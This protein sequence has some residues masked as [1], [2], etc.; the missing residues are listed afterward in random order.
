MDRY[1]PERPLARFFLWNDMHIRARE[2]EHA[3]G[4]YRGSN[5]RAAWAV[6]CAL[7]QHGFAPPD[8][9]VLAGDI[10]NGEEAHIQGEYQAVRE[11]VLD[12]LPMPVLPC[13]GNHETR[14]G[15]DDPRLQGAYE[16]TFGAGWF[17]Y[18]FTLAGFGFIVVDTG[19]AHHIRDER[20][21][22]RN[23]FVGRALERLR[24]MPVFVVTHVP[25]IAMREQ[26]PLMASF[27]F[28]TWRVLDPGLREMVEAHREQVVA[29]LCGHIHLTGVREE[30][31]IYY[32]MP[33]GT[34]ES[35]AD[36]ASLE[37]FTDHVHVRMHAIPEQLNDPRNDIHGALRH[38]I[39]Y[40]DVEH[41]DHESYVRGNR[42][43]RVLTIPLGGEKRPNP[44]AAGG[45]AVYHE[46]DA[47]AGGGGQQVEARFQR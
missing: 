14:Q 38:R 35:P 31:G 46:R 42:D 27:G 23:A 36:F 9:I 18:V 20:T 6:E 29:V 4:G 13:P 5:Q 21:A 33:A 2:V 39:D 3:A 30:R 11:I 25:L 41:P 24:G 34:A 10:V 28:S 17:N 32:I 47:R 22:A 44:E 8:V 40:T 1:E 12:R 45:L 7:G 19:D 26:E 15:A 37:L 43:E 16:E